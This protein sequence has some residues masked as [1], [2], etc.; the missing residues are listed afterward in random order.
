MALGSAMTPA[1]EPTLL[2]L[3]DLKGKG[4]DAEWMPD[5]KR[6]VFVAS[7][8]LWMLSVPGSEAPA[9]VA[10]VGEDGL[11]PVVSRQRP[12]QPS[13]LVYVRSYRDEN[14]WRIDTAGPGEPASSPPYVSISSTKADLTP[15]FS[16]DGRRV[17]F[18][19][20]RSGSLE[21]W[22]ADSDGANAVQLTAMGAIP[23][24]ARWSPDGNTVV[25]HS[26]PTG[27]PEAYSVPAAGGEPRAITSNPEGA[28]FPSFSRDG[29]WTFISARGTD[30]QQALW[31]FPSG[32]GDQ[33]RVTTRPASMSMMSPDGAYVYFNDRFDRPSTLW[34]V[35]ASGGTESR[36]LD[37][38]VRS[39]FAVLEKGIYYIDQ[40]A[41]STGDNPRDGPS[42]QSRLQYFD[43]ATSTSRTVAR[44][45]G[46]VGLGLTA[47]SD[48][49]TIL[50]T[51]QDASID[52]LMLVE[53]FH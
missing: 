14:I 22:T 31:K 46:T 7:G 12:G 4:R 26:D 41:E 42:V 52:D 40:V 2:P 18:S 45:L 47:S 38:V 17:A 3:G 5:G 15:Q 16:P 24:F 8:G 28:A 43:L 9:R 36:V 39:N 44:N 20:A 10:F 49:R 21:I 23:G 33:I 53:N 51:R 37:G 11:M 32:G 35:P 30:R 6:I 27:H 19:S 25:F 13:R 29:R 48:G 1:G 50:F 34:R